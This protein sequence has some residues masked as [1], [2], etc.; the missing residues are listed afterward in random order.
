MELMYQHLNIAGSRVNSAG[1]ALPP[2]EIC[3][4]IFLRDIRHDARLEPELCFVLDHSLDILS[5]A[6]YYEKPREATMPREK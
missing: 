3:L 5:Q 2:F 1:S 6:V 4:E